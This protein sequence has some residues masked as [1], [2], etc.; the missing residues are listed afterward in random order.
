MA[1]LV[2]A[3]ITS[4]LPSRQ[5]VFEFDLVEP[6]KPDGLPEARRIVLVS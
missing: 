5:H 6:A 4:K 2:D 3:Q 1:S